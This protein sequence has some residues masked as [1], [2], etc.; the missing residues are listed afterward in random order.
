VAIQSWA[1][2]GG[3]EARD[4]SWDG[5]AVVGRVVDV[6]LLIGKDS[7]LPSSSRDEILSCIGWQH[8]IWVPH[9]GAPSTTTIRQNDSARITCYRTHTSEECRSMS[10]NSR[11]TITQ[12]PEEM[13]RA[14]ETEEGWSTGLMSDV[15]RSEAEERESDFGEDDG[16]H[17]Y[18]PIINLALRR[19]AL[20]TILLSLLPLPAAGYPQPRTNAVRRDRRRSSS[21]RSS[22]GLERRLSERSDDYRQEEKE[23]RIR[24]G[25]SRNR[26]VH[27]SSANKRAAVTVESSEV[28]VLSIH[29]YS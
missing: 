13:A 22:R 19:T 27:T 21:P 9:T 15:D 18:R 1:H 5:W 29:F 11:K 6:L 7:K 16:S 4:G 8:Y 12:G 25:E 10:R 28:R 3:K 14:D 17:E 2:P 26:D 20:S 23:G 24:V